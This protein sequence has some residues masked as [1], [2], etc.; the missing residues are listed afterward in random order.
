MRQT[1]HH[2]LIT[3]LSLL[4]AGCVTLKHAVPD[5]D[6]ATYENDTIFRVA[7]DQDGYIYPEPEVRRVEID[8][9]DIDNLNLTL[10]NYFKYGQE[11]TVYLKE[12]PE[13][14]EFPDDLPDDLK[15]KIAYDDK[16]HL[17]V[18][19]GRMHEKDRIRLRH[20]SPGDA[21]YKD[22]IEALYRE[23]K[24]EYNPARIT[25]SIAK[26]INNSLLPGKTLIIL[27]HGFNNNYNE[28]DIYFRQL[29]HALRAYNKENNEKFDFVF[30]QV[31]WDG[32]SATFWL[33]AVTN[34]KLV[35]VNGLRKLLDAL[36]TGAPA[37]VPTR[38]I[39][40]SRGASVILS[41]LGNPHFSQTAK[42]RLKKR[43][44]DVD[45][46]MEAPIPTLYDLRIAM[47]APAI[48]A[49]DFDYIIR[50][51][52]DT[53]TEK[54]PI[55]NIIVG[56]NET[57]L[58]LNKLFLVN[59]SKLV[60]TAFGCDKAEYKKVRNELNKKRPGFMSMADFTGQKIHAFTEY[61][62][63]PVFSECLIPKLLENP[64]LACPQ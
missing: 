57:D 30:L 3:L 6:H 18:F 21:T 29:R 47:V 56:F 37:N 44:E 62:R 48:G 33:K 26:K 24:Y 12:M 59:P 58:I 9:D 19:K 4:I 51:I 49:G 8:K 16:N 28:A 55:E 38:V 7:F 45:E 22:A 42:E 63:N 10:K 39:T 2:L 1:S 27:I 15:D 40:H 11:N 32:L 25:E 46:M 34:S 23:C 31:Y 20:L 35:G 50:N 54:V 5:S 52:K 61:I 14:L 64:A 41:A 13:G 53:Y 60:S 36:S 43:G 17:L